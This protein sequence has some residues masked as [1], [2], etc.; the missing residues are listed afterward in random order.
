[1][2]E[3]VT[4]D[5]FDRGT[6]GS[7]RFLTTIEMTGS[8]P[9]NMPITAMCRLVCHYM[10]GHFGQ[11]ALLHACDSLSDIYLWQIEQEQ[12]PTPLGQPFAAI[13]QPEQR[14]LV[15]VQWTHS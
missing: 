14:V 3:K 5:T 6:R 11:A 7:A 10:L 9:A 13:E 12:A 8:D 2:P 4:F 15:A 1:M